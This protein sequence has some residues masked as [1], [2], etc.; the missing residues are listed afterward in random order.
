MKV[1]CISKYTQYVPKHPDQA[2]CGPT[3]ANGRIR[4]VKQPVVSAIGCH[5]EAVSQP[6]LVPRLEHIPEDVAE[7]HSRLQGWSWL[8]S[9][10]YSTIQQPTGCVLLQG[11]VVLK[12]PC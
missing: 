8:L 7:L 6:L 4:A 12:A 3:S 5:F 11:V 1:A 9:S 2:M 10:S